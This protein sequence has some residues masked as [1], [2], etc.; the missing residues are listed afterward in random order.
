MAVVPFDVPVT[1]AQPGNEVAD[2]GRELARRFQAEMFRTGE[3]GIVELF[4]RDRWPGKRDDFFGGNYQAIKLA[5]DAGYDLVVLGFL[6]TPTNAEE[7]SLNVKI[8]D[9][10]NQMTIWYGKTDVYAR[11]RS[12]QTFLANLAGLGLATERPDIFHFSERTDDLVYC[13]VSYILKSEQVP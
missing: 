5:R 6:E 12:Q 8:I 7:L 3:F 10:D 11:A 1:F 13:S 9:T 4:D 2:Y